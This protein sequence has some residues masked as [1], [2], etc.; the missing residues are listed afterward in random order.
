L[1]IP[2]EALVF[3]GGQSQVFVVD[4]KTG[5]VAQRRVQLGI[6]GAAQVEILDGLEQGEL[7]VRQ[8]QHRL[9]SGAKVQWAHLAPQNPRAPWVPKTQVPQT[10]VAS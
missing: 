10:R 1:L 9:V 5:V 3:K 2:F 7:I 6:Q 4:R 8:G